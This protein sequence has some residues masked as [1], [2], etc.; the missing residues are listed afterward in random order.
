MSTNGDQQP[1]LGTP[2]A[3]Q[4]AIANTESLLHLLKAIDQRG[5][6]AAAG[7]NDSLKN[8]IKHADIFTAAMSAQAAVALP[9]LYGSKMF[10]HQI[11]RNGF[12]FD[13]NDDYDGK[14][15]V[16]W[17]DCV[18]TSF[19]KMGEAKA[20]VDTI[21]HSL[22]GLKIADNAREYNQLADDYLQAAAD[23]MQRDAEMM[24]PATDTEEFSG[25]EEEPEDE[26]SA[27]REEST[28][29]SECIRHWTPENEGSMAGLPTLTQD[30]YPPTH[31]PK[32]NDNSAGGQPTA[33]SFCHNGAPC[34]DY[35]YEHYPDGYCPEC[36]WDEAPCRQPA[37]HPGPEHGDGQNEFSTRS[38]ADENAMMGAVPTT[39]NDDWG[40]AEPATAWDGPDYDE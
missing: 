36:Y 29:P 38:D 32:D 28:W 34:A 14:T 26:N 16:K 13:S 33:S 22:A 5:A 18:D 10:V 6:F 15:L 20:G 7:R 31:P 30:D 27:A 24:A 2:T 21:T 39:V 4:A 11:T 8:F 3:V 1:A 37:S 25:E 17:Q 9:I 19:V 40:Q 35:A 23:A 12:E